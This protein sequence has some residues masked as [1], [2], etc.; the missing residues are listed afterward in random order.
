MLNE[1]EKALARAR[2][3]LDSSVTFDEHL[4]IRDAF[5]PFKSPLYWVWALISEFN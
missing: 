5:R 3:L 1:R 2:I 4:N